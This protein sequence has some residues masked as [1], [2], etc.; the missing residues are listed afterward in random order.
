MSE[1]KTNNLNNIIFYLIL[2]SFM[3]SLITFFSGILLA[4]NIKEG[5]YFIS[6]QELIALIIVPFLITVLGFI[7]QLVLFRNDQKEQLR[8]YQSNIT[9][10]KNTSDFFIYSKQN[11]N[12]RSL[13]YI[14][15]YEIN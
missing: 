4:P 15:I 9:M 7:L 8:I 14:N 6:K 13:L 2:G 10:I 3:I 12:E 11:R 1:K 5:N